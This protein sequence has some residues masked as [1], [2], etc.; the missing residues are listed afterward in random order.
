M[1]IL[2]T[3]DYGWGQRPEFRRPG[4]E[5]HGVFVPAKLQKKDFAGIK[6]GIDTDVGLPAGIASDHSRPK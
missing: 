4:M 2:P 5:V 3:G 6:K 1:R